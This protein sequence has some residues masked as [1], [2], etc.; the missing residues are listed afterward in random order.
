MKEQEQT[1]TCRICYEEIDR[2]ARAC[3]YCSSPQ[4]GF[5]SWI[6]RHSSKFSLILLLFMTAPAIMVGILL[7][8]FGRGEDFAPYSQQV[9]VVSSA[10]HFEETEDGPVVWVIGKVQ[11]DSKIDWKEIQFEVQFMNEAG[12]LI[13][14]ERRVQSFH[15]PRVLPGGEAG[16]KIKAS[17]EFSKEKYASQ[18][19]FIR[20]A[21][22]ARSRW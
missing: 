22:D 6:V 2:R 12:E 10:M 20:Y 17:R 21:K 5:A 8:R 11:N 13:D 19:V 3:R 4:A 16:F 14:V 18:K 7:H 1:K 9:R 15:E